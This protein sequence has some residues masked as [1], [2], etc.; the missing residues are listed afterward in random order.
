LQLQCSNIYICSSG[1]PQ[2][3]ARRKAEPCRDSPARCYKGR[4]ARQRS[5]QQPQRMFCPG[6]RGG[7]VCVRRPQSQ[8]K[9][10]GQRRGEVSQHS[11]DMTASPHRQRWRDVEWSRGGLEPRCPVP[12]CM[13][14]R[15][16]GEVTAAVTPSSPGPCT[17]LNPSCPGPPTCNAI[18]CPT[19][20]VPFLH[21]SGPGPKGYG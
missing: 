16:R 14:L 11:D 13:R 17:A 15:P 9:R 4:G 10:P 7:Q 2:F 18:A 5:P 6:P 12:V 8:T 3:V 1:G 20:N 19:K 21:A